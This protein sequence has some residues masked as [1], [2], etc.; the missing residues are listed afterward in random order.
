MAVSST[1]RVEVRA[2]CRSA[3]RDARRAAPVL[4]Q[5]PASSAYRTRAAP[6]CAPSWP[7]CGCDGTQSGHREPEPPWYLLS[8]VAERDQPQDLGLA[9]GEMRWAAVLRD[10]AGRKRRAERRLQVRSTGRNALDRLN[11]L[12]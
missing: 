12:L 1:I 10:G 5:N 11:Q 4:V 3:V 9:G 7:E 8:R 6:T 2:S